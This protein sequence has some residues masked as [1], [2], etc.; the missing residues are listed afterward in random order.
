MDWRKAVRQ[1]LIGGITISFIVAVGMFQV[2]DS[3]K[4]IDPFL[5]AGYV[6]I[7]WVPIVFG[8]RATRQVLPDGVERRPATGK[9]VIAGAV[10]GAITGLVLGLV[11]VLTALKPD[12]RNSFLF[13]S[14]QMVEKFSYGQSQWFGVGVLT[15]GGALLGALGGALDLI[16]ATIKRILATVAATV[17]AFNFA[18]LVV[19]DILRS[20][21]LRAID[22][23][24]Y[25]SSRG[26]KPLAALVLSVIFVA[27]RLLLRGRT[28]GIRQRIAT[29]NSNGKKSWYLLLALIA[30]AAGAW[31]PNVFG[32]YL[33]EV[34]S[35]VGLF[36]LL[37]LGLNIVVGYAGLLDLGYVAFFA[38][39]AYTM[40]VLTSPASQA[41]TPEMA[42]FE[43]LPWVLLMAA[44]AGLIIGTPV[45]RM[46]GDYLAIVTL[47]FGEII[48][49]AF[50][51]D[52]LSPITGGAQGILRAGYFPGENRG[53]VIVQWGL[54]LAVAGIVALI[55]GA[56]R[57]NASRLIESGRLSEVTP[58][59]KPVT[60][61][62]LAGGVVAVVVGLL[63]PD[64][65][66]WVIPG[67]HPPSMFRI[68]LVFV[69]IAAFVSWR[70]RD[71]RVG[72]SWMAIREDEQIAQTMGINIVTTKLLAFVMG[73]MLASLGGALFAVKLGSIYP[74]SFEII[75]SIIILVVVIV[76]GMG[77]IKGVMIG[78][79][80]LIGILGGPT[81]PGLLRE[82]GEF[83]LLI[84]GVILVWMMLKRPE[85][86]WPEKRRAQELHQEEMA[87]DAWLQVEQ[88]PASEG[89]PG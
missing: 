54:V 12:I 31:L 32:L 77:S 85:G 43:A 27:A 53:G 5:S 35:N 24:L 18:E 68:V 37:G 3:R 28:A 23:F 72:R 57:W 60:Y 20:A 50:L 51:S 44:I 73:A 84:Y 61:A 76:G 22:Q 70:L 82:F 56:L 26:L 48:R 8:Y 59:R 71:S 1:G 46:R 34:L 4:V 66:T 21:G 87:Q 41:L 7:L 29:Q 40:A 42:F 17:I 64:F 19:G 38:V 75:Q 2:F 58:Y 9:D 79:I 89:V 13:L 78:A 62:L 45:I 47:G 86:L 55:V 6:L 14:P 88:E 16:P 69:A 30:L 15:A 81:Q 52:W 80:V 83:K 33:N 11:V 49:I 63:F 36:I 10:A 67:I 39:G 74:H 25:T 65:A